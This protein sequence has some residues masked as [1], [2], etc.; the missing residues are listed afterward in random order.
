MD[1]RKVEVK[2]KRKV[3]REE[4]VEYKAREMQEL[5]N[6]EDSILNKRSRTDSVSLP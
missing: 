1:K 5:S 4:K 2:K 6:P 3:Y